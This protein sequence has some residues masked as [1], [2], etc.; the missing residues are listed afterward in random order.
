M[1]AADGLLLDTHLLVWAAYDPDRL[2]KRA[3]RLIRQRSLRVV[4]SLAS[5]WEVAIKASL[6]RGDFVVDAD[7]LHRGLL[8]EGFTELPIGHAHIA[9]VATLPWVH[10]DPFDRMLVAQ[11]MV[12]G[13]TLLSA[14]SALKGY[15]RVVRAV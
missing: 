13:L 7:Q 6:G 8:S 4:F 15:G 1:A 2:P 14:D 9:R 3:A 11:A 5:L 10:R 12:E